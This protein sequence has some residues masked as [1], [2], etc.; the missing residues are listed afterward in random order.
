MDNDIY[1]SKCR[2]NKRLVK[3]IIPFA[4][5]HWPESY[6]GLPAP[7]NIFSRPLATVDQIK[8]LTLNRKKK[9]YSQFRGDFVGK[10]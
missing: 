4:V 5:K 3:L 8:I 9:S 6:P 10:G 1:V 2:P 7:V